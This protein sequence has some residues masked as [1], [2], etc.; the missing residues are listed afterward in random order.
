MCLKVCEIKT[1]KL[2]EKFLQFVFFQHKLPCPLH[3]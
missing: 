1:K 3:F 2:I